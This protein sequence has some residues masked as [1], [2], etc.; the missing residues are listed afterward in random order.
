MSNRQT[1]KDALIGRYFVLIMVIRWTDAIL[2]W[3]SFLSQLL[4]STSVSEIYFKIHKM[5]LKQN[6][7]KIARDLIMGG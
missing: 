7:K 6:E 1:V 3:G 5:K 4:K 2:D